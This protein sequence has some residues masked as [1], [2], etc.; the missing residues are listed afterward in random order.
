MAS[1]K[2]GSALENRFGWRVRAQSLTPSAAAIA[3]DAAAALPPP[4][5]DWTSA[6]LSR[7]ESISPAGDASSKPSSK[8]QLLQEFSHPKR[9]A[10]ARSEGLAATQPHTLVPADFT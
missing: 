9:C 2:K 6:K 4:A 8:I 3:A 1:R 10:P 7:N 5:G